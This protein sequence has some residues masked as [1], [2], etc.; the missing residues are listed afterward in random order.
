MKICFVAAFP[1]SGGPLNEYSFHM[2]REIQK[3][4]GIELTI[5]ADELEDLPYST[6]AAGNPLSTEQQPELPGFHVI[7]CWKFGSMATPV[8]LL[9]TIRQINPDVVWFNLVFSSF[10]TYDKPLAAFAGLSVPALTRAA[11]YFT[12]VTLHHIVEHVDFAASGVRRERLYRLGTNM[13][14]RTLLR[15]D[16]VSVLLSA[17]WRTLVQKYEARNIVLGTHGIFS[18]LPSP[19][20]FSQRGNPELRI[21]AFGH[22][23]TYKRLETLMAAFPAVLKQVPNARLIVGGGNHPTKIGY[24]ESV[25]DAQPK[26]L[27]IEFRGYVPQRDVP[28]LFATSS[29]LVMPY[30]SSTGSSGPAHQACEY[31]V[32]ILCADIEDFRCMSN[33]EDMSIEFYKIGDPVDLA[34]K[35]VA[36]LQAPELLKEMGK[37]NYH[38]GIRM[39]MASVA[40]TYLRWFELHR[41]KRLFAPRGRLAGYRKRWLGRKGL[42]GQR[43]QQEL[44]LPGPTRREEHS[45]SAG[46]VDHTKAKSSL[47]G[48]DD[49][50]GLENT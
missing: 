34:K 1:P 37:H 50:Q 29:L 19:P 49:S 11:G 46:K 43:F 14:T 5:L 13:V 3:H 4:P 21:L 25:R 31:G 47:N 42:F 20:D 26:E 24:W 40:R 48:L 8:R 23:G 15:A 18:Q 9:K 10:G 45:G 32:P 6:D 33:D 44:N 16:S 36:L 38:A 39:N 30:D 7:R 35:L 2:A 27:P 41:Q 28:A 17:Y 12:H 22:W